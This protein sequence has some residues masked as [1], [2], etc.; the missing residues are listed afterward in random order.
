M[1]DFVN[2]RVFVLKLHVQ[3][4]IKKNQREPWQESKDFYA[5]IVS[6]QSDDI[7]VFKIGLK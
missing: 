6:F 1:R 5:E 7:F 4:G 2:M 3:C